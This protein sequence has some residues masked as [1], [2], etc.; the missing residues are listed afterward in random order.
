V[1]VRLGDHRSG[2][3]Y[4]RLAKVLGRSDT[5]LR[6]LVRILDADPED[7][8]LAQQGRIS[9]REARRRAKRARERREAAERQHGI[10]ERRG[11]LAA[12]A[13]GV[14]SWLAH[15]SQASPNAELIVIEARLLMATAGNAGE[16]PS[17]TASYSSNQHEV[18]RCTRPE[19]SPDAFSISWYAS[20]LANWLNYTFDRQIGWV[21][22]NEALHRMSTTR[23]RQDFG[24]RL[25]VANV[26][27]GVEQQPLQVPA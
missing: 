1:Q 11:K 22:L 16:L 23:W 2:F 24:T 13:E 3:S 21:V 18:I 5:L 20:W 19:G 15:E 27:H 26:N 7:L 17:R 10:E 25:A 9:T 6:G 4:R 14:L 8:D 12:A